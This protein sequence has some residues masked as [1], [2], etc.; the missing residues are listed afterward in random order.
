MRESVKGPIVFRFLPI[1][2]PSTLPRLHLDIW[3]TTSL[4]C[5]DGTIGIGSSD[6]GKGVN[7]NKQEPTQENPFADQRSPGNNPFSR[8]K[9]GEDG[10]PG[11]SPPGGLSPPQSRDRRLSKEWGTFIPTFLFILASL[12]PEQ[13]GKHLPSFKNPQKKPFHVSYL[14]PNRL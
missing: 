9:T 11:T 5:I 12:L 3:N 2:C 1:F 4:T 14:K 6:P 7:P 13:R 10:L 8:T